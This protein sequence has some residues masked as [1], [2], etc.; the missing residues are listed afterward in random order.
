M[1]RYQ[2]VV[3]GINEEGN[4][5]KQRCN[6]RAT[7]CEFVNGGVIFYGRQEGG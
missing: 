1:R 2:V 5:A 6:N 3:V 7:D 4:Q